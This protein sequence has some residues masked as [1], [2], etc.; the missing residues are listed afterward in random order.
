MPSKPKAENT[1]ESAGTRGPES[2]L[3]NPNAPTY[4]VNPTPLDE[5]GNPV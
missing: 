2:Q 5:N 4:T 1:P 3:D